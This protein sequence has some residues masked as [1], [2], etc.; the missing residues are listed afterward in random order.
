[1]GLGP[2]W[3]GGM[4][5]GP[6][7]P[8]GFMVTRRNCATNADWVVVWDHYSKRWSTPRQQERAT[9]LLVHGHSIDILI[10]HAEILL[11]LLYAGRRN[12]IEFRNK[13]LRSPIYSRR[14]WYLAV[15]H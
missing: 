3:T 8:G 1:M 5:L 12:T 11:Q 2:G 15:G 14:P 10:S 9:D 13:H 7:A 6:G 4:L